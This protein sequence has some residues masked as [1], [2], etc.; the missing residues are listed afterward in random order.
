MK[1][2]CGRSTAQGTQEPGAESEDGE[3]PLGKEE[4][5][6][7]G[8]EETE[9]GAVPGERTQRVLGESGP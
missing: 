4:A 2:S 3:A 1:G 6:L 7:P 8:V 5:D 9:Y